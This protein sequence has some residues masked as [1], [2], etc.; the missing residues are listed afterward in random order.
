VTKWQV[1]VLAY[2]SLGLGLLAAVSFIL[3][4]N[5]R[6]STTDFYVATPVLA[7]AAT[8]IGAVSLFNRRG[9]RE[10]AFGGVALGVVTLAV[11]LCLVGAA[12]LVV[13]SD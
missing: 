4:V 8:V 7:L 9:S 13:L 1:R 6:T 11:F 2:A 3:A 10:A 5:G 12:A